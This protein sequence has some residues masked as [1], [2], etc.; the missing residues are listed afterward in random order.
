MKLKYNFVISSVAGKTVAVAVGSD[1]SEF[2]GIVE[3][4]ATAEFMFKVLQ[5]KDTT[6][7]ELVLPVKNNYGID[8][9][10]ARKAVELFVSAMRK[11]GLIEE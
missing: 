7:D 6:F 3:L 8:D 5:N 9:E 11:N 1:S 2:N 10:T 4:N